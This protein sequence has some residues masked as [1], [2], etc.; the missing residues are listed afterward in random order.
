MDAQQRKALESLYFN[1]AP[2]AD[3]LWQ[4]QGSLHVGGLH[5]EAL[6]E[7][8]AAYRQA[9]QQLQSNPLGVVIRGQAGSGKTHLLGQVRAQVQDIGGFF[10][11]VELLDG[12]NFWR[13][14]RGGILES[15]GRPTVKHETQ[16][17]HLL[18]ELTEHART[19]RVH[20]KAILGQ[21][22]L[23]PEVLNDFVIG[24]RKV[25]PEVKNYQQTLRALV[26]LASSDFELQDIGEAFLISTDL[27]DEVREHWGLDTPP[28]G[29]EEGVRAISRL[30]ALAG[31]AIM[32]LDQID[33]LLAQSAITDTDSGNG[34]LE[35]V[36]QGLLLSRE[37]TR[38]TVTV[39]ACLPSVW[40]LIRLRAVA[41]VKDRYRAPAI[42]GAPADR[43]DRPRHSRTSFD[44][45]LP[46][47]RLHSATPELADCGK[48]VRRRTAT[49]SA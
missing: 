20:R 12:S 40:E 5:D 7:V 22:D 48:G 27:S 17:K 39:V 4:S 35:R 18:W 14:A 16:L 24:M 26:L 10:F 33:G 42:L 25:H 2:A 47:G 8:M 37:I 46:R 29:P 23:T 15:L 13:S 6:N 36:A 30:V 44:R 21:N 28:H 41:P 3:D 43:C 1:F 34:D 31:P 32:A 19:S 38:R 49:D 11:M 9:E 45:V